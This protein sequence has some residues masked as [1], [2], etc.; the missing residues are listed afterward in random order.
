MEK[1]KRNGIET[2]K[3]EL[4]E[5]IEILEELLGDYNDGRR[6]SFFCVAVNLLELSAIKAVMGQIKSTV[7]PE[8]SAKE[9]ATV[10]VRLLS[11]MAEQRDISLKLR[12][13]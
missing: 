12:K 10:A 5:K 1:A 7:E 4:N 3:S 8:M 2:Y 13:K 6:K 11:E 9:K